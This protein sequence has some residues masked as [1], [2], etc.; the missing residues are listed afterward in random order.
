MLAPTRPQAQT[1]GPHP[2][3]TTP[4]AAAVLRRDRFDPQEQDYYEALYTQS[5]AQ[6]GTFVQAGTVLN[7]YAHV[8]ELLIRLR[9]AVNHPYLVVHSAS[10]QHAQQGGGAFGAV[11]AALGSPAAAP[12]AAGEGVVCGI[13]HDPVEDAV[14][15]A[16]GH[17]FCRLCAV[18]YTESAAGEFSV[19]FEF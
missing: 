7:N 19:C 12:A 16:C 3:P 11:A 14:S 17:S 4:A 15:A 1:L 8:F 6:F 13:C 5:R 10:A 9:Q 18:E 2:T